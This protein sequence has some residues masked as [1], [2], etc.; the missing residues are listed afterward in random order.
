MG[1]RKWKSCSNGVRRFLSRMG[2]SG[3][4]FAP[5]LKEAA[6]MKK[7]LMRTVPAI[8][9]PAAGPVL[10]RT[11][12]FPAKKPI[13][14][15]DLPDTWRVRLD[16][17]DA[18]VFAQSPHRNIEYILRE[19]E[20]T[21]VKANVTDL[22]NDAVKEADAVS[23]ESVSDPQFTDWK[24]E[25]V[26]G[27]QFLW[28]TGTGKDKETGGKVNMEVDFFSTDGKREFV[29]PYYGMPD[30]E[31]RYEQEIDKIDRSIKRIQ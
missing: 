28:A 24:P 2:K 23:A 20:R 1:K 22:L 10:A 29:L 5:T 15:V 16:T 9:L 25:T 3:E 26:N 4:A 11:Y 31:R 6:A 21:A 17:E 13:L 19:L 30:G 7:S 12:T 18:D 8:A 27:M 14:S